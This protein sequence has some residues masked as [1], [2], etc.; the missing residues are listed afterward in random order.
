MALTKARVREILSEAG[1]ATEKLADAVDKIIDGHVTSIEALREEIKTY[2]GDA[3]KLP[4]VQ[5]ELDDLKKTVA[6]GGDWEKKFKDKDTEFKNFKAEVEAEKTK[7]EKTKLFKAALKAA[8]VDEKRFDAILKVTNLDDIKLKD[9]KFADEK[10]VADSIKADW[11]DFIVKQKT[12]GASVET[13]PETKGGET[14]PQS[15]AAI[16]AAK[17]N[18]NRYGSI[19]SGQQTN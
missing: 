2:K 11:S 14:K 13:P 10:S 3:E 12:Q 18:E 1:V 15:R 9:G 7:A 19:K 6:D 16:L 4:E 5:K 8:N 17:Y